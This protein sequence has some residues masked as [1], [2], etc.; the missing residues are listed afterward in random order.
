MAMTKQCL[1]AIGACEAMVN[2]QDD[3]FELGKRIAA[4]GDGVSN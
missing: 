3:D 1:E 2:C 4:R